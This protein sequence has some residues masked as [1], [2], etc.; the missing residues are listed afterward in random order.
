MLGMSLMGKLVVT[1]SSAGLWKKRSGVPGVPL[2]ACPRALRDGQARPSVSC[3]GPAAWLF[4]PFSG[5][6]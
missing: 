4:F 3:L 1:V 2:F 5:C 6:L